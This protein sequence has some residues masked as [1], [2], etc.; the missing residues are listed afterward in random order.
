MWAAQADEPEPGPRGAWTANSALLTWPRWREGIPELLL[1]SY[2]LRMSIQASC[3]MSIDFLCKLKATGNC[4]ILFSGGWSQISI[5]SLTQG[6]CKNPV[7][8]FKGLE[9]CAAQLHICPTAFFEKWVTRILKVMWQ[10]SRGRGW[11]DTLLVWKVAHGEKTDCHVQSEICSIC[12][13]NNNYS[14]MGKLIGV[15]VARDIFLCC[16]VE[17]IPIIVSFSCLT[18][19]I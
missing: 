1:P 5:S 7:E 13:L 17:L 3:A 16:H 15:E 18:F 19:T 12:D 14:P 8:A 11:E 6:M 2:S 10:C 9:F 4:N